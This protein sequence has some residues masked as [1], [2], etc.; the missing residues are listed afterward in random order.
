MSKA[1]CSTDSCSRPSRTRGMC[2]N[3]YQQWLYREGRTAQ[4]RKHVRRDDL[5]T[6]FRSR[7][8]VVAETGCWEWVGGRAEGYGVL[9][10]DGAQ[11]KAHRLAL[12]LDGRNP[13]PGQL[14]CHRCDNRTCVNPAHLYWGSHAD[15]NRD[16]SERDRYPLG[17]ARRNSK[18]TEG[19]VAAIRNA[20]ALGEQ[21]ATLARLYGVSAPTIR[22]IVMG[23]KWRHVAGPIT[24]NGSK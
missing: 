17:S 12:Q 20:A 13:L 2:P 4:G 7:Y 10:H 11:I 23:L 15:N 21:K 1:T 18:L 14:A 3:H 19:Q 6:R 16:A 9:V 8:R 22:N 24:T 5:A